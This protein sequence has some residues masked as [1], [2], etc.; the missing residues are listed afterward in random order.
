MKQTLINWLRMPEADNIANLDVPEA[1]SVHHGF[2]RQ[3]TFLNK[4]YQDSYLK[5]KQLLEPISQNMNIVELGSGSGFIKEVIPQA[6]SSDILEVPTVD[7]SFSGEKIP[8][9]SQ[10]VDAFLMIDVFHHVKDSKIFLDEMQRCLKPGGKILMIEPANSLWGRFIWINFHHEQFNPQAGWK[11]DGEGP[12]SDAN[13]AL[14]WIVFSRDKEKFQND[15]PELSIGLFRT[16]TPLRYLISGGLTLKQLLPGFCYPLIK[17][18]E[19]LL[20][21]FNHWI[22]MFYLIE[23]KKKEEVH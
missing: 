16:H 22:G 11:V 19:L 13:G 10:S 9:K 14:P 18:L 7:I 1:L 23:L 3:K 12:M 2:I 4:V 6:I 17:F 8:F 20:T 21:P 15:Y 5:F